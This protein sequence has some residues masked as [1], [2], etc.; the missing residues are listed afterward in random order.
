MV[1]ASFDGSVPGM[2]WTLAQ[3][4]EAAAQ[5]KPAD[6]HTTYRVEGSTIIGEWAAD[7]GWA[8][9]S[10]AGRQAET[11]RVEV[12]LSDEQTYRMHE[13]GGSS[14]AGGGADPSGASLHAEKTFF[15]GH[16]RRWS[17]QSGAAPQV[18][19]SSAGANE[20][21]N[22]FSYTFDSEKVKKPVLDLLEQ[23]GWSSQGGLL[24]R[25]F[26]G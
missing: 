10:G 1:V 18:D 4:R 14:E 6:E 21:G 9:P 12:E 15:S 7:A 11:Y 17:F 23:A 20:E 8:G 25:I 2:A 26:G 22:T 3:V 16:E 24:S 13:T 19:P 5:L